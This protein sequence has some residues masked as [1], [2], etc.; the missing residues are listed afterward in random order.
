MEYATIENVDG[1]GMA[2]RLCEWMN[3]LDTSPVLNRVV[4]ATKT[5]HH[6]LS[7]LVPLMDRAYMRVFFH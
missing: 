7:D 2:S 1:L 3:E 4:M 6:L 5:L